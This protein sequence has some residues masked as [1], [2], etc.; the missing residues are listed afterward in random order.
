[1]SCSLRMDEQTDM[2]KLTVA[3]RNF[4]K[5]PKKTNDYLP[6]TTCTFLYTPATATSFSLYAKPSSGCTRFYKKAHCTALQVILFKV[7]CLIEKLVQ[8]HNFLVKYRNT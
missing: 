4:A 2:S 3:Y 6:K 5:A 8:P 1:M 7:I